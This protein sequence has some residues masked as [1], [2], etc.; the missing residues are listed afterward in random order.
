MSQFSSDLI[1]KL[2]VDDYQ[3]QEEKMRLIEQSNAFDESILGYQKHALAIWHKV[4]ERYKEHEN[5][6]SIPYQMA[7]TPKLYAID[8]IIITEP[9]LKDR[10]D[11]LDAIAQIF[12]VFYL[13]V[14]FFDDHVEHRDKFYS[15]FN[16]QDSENETQKG[17]A[18]FSFVLMSFDIIRDILLELKQ[19]GE[20]VSCSGIERIITRSLLMQT[21]YFSAERINSLSV[22]EVLEIK[23]R[24]VSGAATSVIADLLQSVHKFDEGELQALR[25]GLI[26]VGSLTQI[27]DDI[28]DAAV[29]ATLRNANIVNVAREQFGHEEGMRQL[30]EIYSQEESTA[31]ASLDQ[32]YSEESV[33]LILSIPFYPFFVDKR[34]L[35][36]GKYT[37]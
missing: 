16:F 20:S 18:P 15:K 6:Y 24:Q 2:V 8:P 22:D 32:L 35:R 31:K 12:T 5:A 25:D 33:K 17:A 29:D 19:Q 3:Q 28:R 26:Y 9:F 30:S 11:V 23:Q 1:A 10:K 13:V 4:E 21:R 27:T 7:E 34:Q 37:Q 14:H 36:E